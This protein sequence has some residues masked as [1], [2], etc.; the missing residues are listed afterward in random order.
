MTALTWTISRAARKGGA[1]RRIGLLFGAVVLAWTGG[2]AWFIYAAGRPSRPLPQSADAIVVLTGGA[3][4]VRAGLHLLEDH[5]A[6]H[7]LVTGI[8]GNAGFRTLAHQAGI[9]PAPLAGRVT[10]G[11]GATSTHGNAVE[12]AAWARPRDLRSMIVVTAFYHMPRALAEIGR[13]LPGVVLYSASVSPTGAESIP[14]LLVEEYMK[15]LAAEL[16]LTSLAPSSSPL[17]SNAGREHGD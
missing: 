3:D 6:A 1:A 16:G 10:L 7:L 15:Y 17:L 2:L 14:G 4:R 5:P 12:I 13:A 8:G 11:R 9:D